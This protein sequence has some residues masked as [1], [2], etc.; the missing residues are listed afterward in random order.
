MC[1][2]EIVRKCVVGT[3]LYKWIR[4]YVSTFINQIHSSDIMIEFNLVNISSVLKLGLVTGSMRVLGH[5][6]D[7]GVTNWTACFGF[8][9]K[10]VEPKILVCDVVASNFQKLYEY[11]CIFGETIYHIGK[12]L[13]VYIDSRLQLLYIM[14]VSLETCMT[15]S[16]GISFQLLGGTT[17]FLWRTSQ[18]HS[19]D[20]RVYKS[21]EKGKNSLT[22]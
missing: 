12:W 19:C 3:V 20:L 8:S 7:R 15:F 9:A 1:W 2:K 21:F 13:F 22:F 14:F 10:Y 18:R 4:Y 5:W 17:C 11:D 6:L 16:V